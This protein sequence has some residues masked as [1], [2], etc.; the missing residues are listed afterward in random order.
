[1]LFEGDLNPAGPVR[2]PCDLAEVS[3][4]RTTTIAAMTAPARPSHL[5]ASSLPHAH[6]LRDH[7]AHDLAGAAADRA[8][9]GVSEQ[10]THRPVHVAGAA[11]DLHAEIGDLHVVLGGDGLD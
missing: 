2:V 6:Q 5:I 9:A 4:A 7:V 10:A 8:D 1:M 3:P 11:H